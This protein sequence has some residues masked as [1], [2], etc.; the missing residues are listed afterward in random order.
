MRGYRDGN[1]GLLV[2][3]AHWSRLSRL[4][5][6]IYNYWMDAMKVCTAIYVPHRINPNDFGFLPNASGTLT[7]FDFFCEMSP[8][9]LDELPLNLVQKSPHGNKC[10]H[11]GDP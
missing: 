2:G 3:P 11:I 4:Y 7:F 10:N 9:L 5:I 8:Q 6:Y 1:V